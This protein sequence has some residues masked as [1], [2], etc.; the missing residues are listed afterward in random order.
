MDEPK[1]IPQSPARQN[2]IGG[3][4]LISTDSNTGSDYET[5]SGDEADVSAELGDSPAKQQALCDGDNS[6]SDNSDSGGEGEGKEAGMK[7]AYSVTDLMDELDVDLPTE[8]T[9][10][11]NNT[12]TSGL[13]TQIP[14]RTCDSGLQDKKG[15]SLDVEIPVVE[16]GDTLN[17]DSTYE[18]YNSDEAK[19]SEQTEHQYCEIEFNASRGQPSQVKGSSG[20]DNDKDNVG[21]GVS[22]ER[23]TGPRGS[24]TAPNQ[25]DG[26][27]VPDNVSARPVIPSVAHTLPTH[28]AKVTTSPTVSQQHRGSPRRHSSHEACRRTSSD[29]SD[30]GSLPGTAGSRAGSEQ[31][32]SSPSLAEPEDT[33]LSPESTLLSRRRHGDPIYDD[34]PKSTFVRKQE[35][36]L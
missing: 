22:T 17:R 7:A 19:Q 21:V 16:S 27:D 12:A 31:R 10:V 25:A 4:V 11:S 24:Q 23:D 8:G 26:V 2:A 34:V 30:S 9:E 6:E 5:A 3:D 29:R 32:K 18:S 20:V 35:G 1:N 14:V 36:K 15:S 28:T 33:A 13:D